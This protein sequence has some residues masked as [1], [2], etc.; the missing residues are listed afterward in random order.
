MWPLILDALLPNARTTDDDAYHGDIEELDQALLPLPEPGV[1]YWPWPQTVSLASRW[2]DA[3]PRHSELAD[4]AILF[5]L[6]LFDVSD[7]AARS[8]LPLLVGADPRWTR[9]SSRHA[10]SFLKL[11][12]ESDISESVAGQLRSVLDGLAQVGDEQP[13]EVQRGLE[14]ACPP[15][16][17][18]TSS[19]RM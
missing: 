1:D 15:G 14:N 19:T 5:A 6:K 12:L 17:T 13:L 11:P 10:V 9:S 16:R 8:V 3:Y 2:R 7:D 18:S 4:R